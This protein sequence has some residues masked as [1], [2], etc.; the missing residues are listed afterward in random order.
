MQPNILYYNNHVVPKIIKE[1]PETLREFYSD[2]YSP[3]LFNTYQKYGFDNNNMIFDRSGALPHYLNIPLVHRMPEKIDG[4]NKSFYE[5]TEARCKELLSL[6]KS[7]NVMWSGG[8]DSTYILFMLKHFANDPDQVRIY[9]TYN[10]IVESGDMFERRLSKEFKHII[11]VSAGSELNCIEDGIFV[12]GM[13]GNQLFGP[14]DNYFSTS[15]KAMFHHQFGTPETIYEPYE[16]NVSEEMLQFLQPIIDASPRKIETV[17]D[18]RWYCIF[19]LDWYTALYEHKVLLGSE[20]ANRIH[21]FFNSQE[22]QEW[23]V[24]TKDPFTKV[25]GEPNT[26]RWQMRDVLDEMFGE[27]HYARNKDKKISTFSILDS[28]WLFVFDNM[29]TMFLA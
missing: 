1:N 7:I 9:G 24:N 5:I 2:S 8:I 10:S 14:T 13:C 22:F 20:R 6:G 11:K 23:A 18:L 29:E 19:N 25:R 12:S 3:E 17:N 27:T 28:H 26:H 16:R 21:G 15:P 4:Y